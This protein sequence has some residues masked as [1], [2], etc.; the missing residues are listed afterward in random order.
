M[1]TGSYTG[2]TEDENVAARQAIEDTTG[3]DAYYEIE[4]VTVED[5][6]WGKR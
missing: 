3:L 6:K 5:T 1:Q 4:K 2:M